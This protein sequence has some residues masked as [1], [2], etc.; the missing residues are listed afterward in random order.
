MSART[1]LQDNLDALDI[2]DP[3]YQEYV[4][5]AMLQYRSDAEAEGTLPPVDPE[6]LINPHFVHDGVRMLA[7]VGS[8]LGLFYGRHK[9]TIDPY[10][11]AALVTAFT[12]LLNR[13]LD[14][15]N[16]NNRGPT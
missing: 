10:L 12:T 4:F 5:D 7:K 1:Q 2:E 8:W 6:V 11:D 16:L 14:I 9:S 3:R 13:A 15:R